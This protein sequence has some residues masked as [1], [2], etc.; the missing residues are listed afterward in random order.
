MGANKF[1]RIE[2]DANKTLAEINAIIQV[3]FDAIDTE[4]GTVVSFE[5]DLNDSTYC[6]NVLIAY[7]TP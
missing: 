6:Y 3:E 5:E 4:N 7:T 2:I 1:K